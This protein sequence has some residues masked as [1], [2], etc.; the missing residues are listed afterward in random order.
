MH[1]LTKKVV[2]NVQASCLIGKFEILSTEHAQT[3]TVLSRTK[4]DVRPW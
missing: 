4:T 2:V 3:L 1:E